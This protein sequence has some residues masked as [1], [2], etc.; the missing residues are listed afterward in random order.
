MDIVINHLGRCIQDII[1]MQSDNCSKKKTKID[2]RNVYKWPGGRS[3]L[4]YYKISQA[5]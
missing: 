2:I 5:Y 1:Q 3:T 4:W